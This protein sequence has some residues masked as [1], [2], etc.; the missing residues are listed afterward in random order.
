M[1]SWE[2]AFVKRQHDYVVKV[3]RSGFKHTHNLESFERLA[4]EIDFFRSH[5][6]LNHSEK[7]SRQE[8][9]PKRCAVFPDFIHSGGISVK[10]FK[11]GTWHAGAY[12]LYYIRYIVVNG[13]CRAM[14]AE[15]GE[16]RCQI[17]SYF[18]Y[19]CRSDSEK[20]LFYNSFG[21]GIC[22]IR[23]YV[24]NGWVGKECGNI[25]IEKRFRPGCVACPQLQTYNH[26][27]KWRHWSELHRKPHCH[28]D[29]W[30]VVIGYSPPERYKQ[31]FVGEYHGSVNR[32]HR[33]GYVFWLCQIGQ[34]GRCYLGLGYSRG[35]SYDF[36]VR[37]GG[38]RCFRQ[39]VQRLEFLYVALYKT[40]GAVES[41][42]EGR[43][44]VVPV[45]ICR[46]A[47]SECG[48]YL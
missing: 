40:T 5:Y 12:A 39:R 23:G 45:K 36:Y 21:K 22:L 32:V 24:F 47:A 2:D 38:N 25:F 1:L 9:D 3:K 48:E 10:K 14:V 41:V 17:R 44:V 18:R 16:N 34:Q 33:V 13:V 20:T 11:L 46:S 35:N 26:A 15:Y 37:K 19:V 43:A 29:V 30:N 4:D 28:V 31:R 8:P 6:A 27:H 7:C 42:A